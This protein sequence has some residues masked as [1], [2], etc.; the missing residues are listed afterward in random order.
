M[1]NNIYITMKLGEPRQSVDTFI[2]SDT[3]EFYFSDHCKEDI[4]T[5]SS[6]PYLDDV[7]SDI[8][9]FY[10]KS[11]SKTYNNTEKSKSYYKGGTHTGNRTI[12][13]FE[14]N[15]ELE[16]INFILY[17]STPGNMPAVLGFGVETYAGDMPYNFINQLK[18]NDIIKSYYY[19]IKYTSENEGFFIIGDQP[20]IYDPE[21]YDISELKTTYS[22]V[23]ISIGQLGI[24][25]DKIMYQDNNFSP[26]YDC[27]FSYEKNFIEGISKL[28]KIYDEYF[29]EDIEN[30]I[31]VKEAPFYPYDRHKFYHCK[32]NEYAE[33]VKNF[34]SLYFYNNGLNYTF[35][36]DY[37]DLWIERDDKLILLVF[38]SPL[39]SYWYLG[40]PFL[41]KYQFVINPDSK[42]IGFYNQ[43]GKKKIVKENNLL[44]IILICVLFFILIGLIITGVF[45]SKS[46]LGRKKKLNEL[47]SDDGYDYIINEGENNKK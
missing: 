17:N 43:D 11:L 6:T 14:F 41:K 22:F 45:V 3:C 39:G 7:N 4:Y 26:Y 27:Y 19:T 23:Y 32:K 31:C 35:E 47:T 29:K 10:D 2:R 12:D 44:I 28:E 24:R 46:I 34:S 9:N 5:M 33:K 8:K 38:F 20:H 1:H 21:N 36:L 42:T 13:N 40:K 16:K 25:F 30:G 15:N 18:S 37:K